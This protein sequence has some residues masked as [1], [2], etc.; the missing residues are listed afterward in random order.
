[1]HLLPGRLFDFGVPGQDHLRYLTLERTLLVARGDEAIR[2]SGDPLDE[3][4]RGS[5]K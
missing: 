3:A 4:L 5:A 2:G 1:L